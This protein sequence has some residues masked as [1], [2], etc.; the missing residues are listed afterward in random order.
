MV[1]FTV[2]MEKVRFTCTVAPLSHMRPSTVFE[3]VLHVL[4]CSQK[5]G[6]DDL[7]A[8]I[9]GEGKTSRVIC[10][11]ENDCGSPVFVDQSQKFLHCISC[12]MSETELSTGNE[13]SP[14]GDKFFCR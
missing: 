1:D 2:R 11:L 4:A 7:I 9:D 5:Q 14:V 10:W 12:N 13:N 8:A 6:R 3:Q